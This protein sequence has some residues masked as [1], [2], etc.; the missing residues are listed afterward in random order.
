M[1]ERARTVPSQN[2]RLLTTEISPAYTSVTYLP[3]CRHH[4]GVVAR[5]RGTTVN[6]DETTTAWEYNLCRRYQQSVYL[7]RTSLVVTCAT[8]SYRCMRASTTP[9]LLLRRHQYRT[10]V[11]YAASRSAIMAAL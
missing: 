1:V 3:R 5:A 10:P 11:T 7:P 9:A 6:I 2:R 8:R 4:R